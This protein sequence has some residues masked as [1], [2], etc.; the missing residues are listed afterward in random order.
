[1]RLLRQHFRDT[2]EDAKQLSWF[3]VEENKV[4][5]AEEASNRERW[6][7]RE[8]RQVEVEVGEGAGK[9]LCGSGRLLNETMSEDYL[10][11]LRRKIRA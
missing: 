4:G 3:D 11:V 6:R 5:P 9:K 2:A 8:N 7:V 10:R 1:V